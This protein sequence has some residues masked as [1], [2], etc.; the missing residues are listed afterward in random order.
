MPILIE[1]QGTRSAGVCGKDAA[2]EPP[3]MGSRRP[4][5]RMPWDLNA[6]LNG[7]ELCAALGHIRAV[8]KNGFSG[9][10]RDRII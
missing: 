9:N 5:E 7:I 8:E 10:F 2:I 4:V 1:F 3:G 6:Q